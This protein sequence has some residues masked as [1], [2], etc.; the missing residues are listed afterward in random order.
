VFSRKTP[1]ASFVIGTDG[2]GHRVSVISLDGYF[3]NTP[4]AERPAFI[5][6]NI[7]SAEKGARRGATQTIKHRK[8]KQAI[9]AYHKPE[10]I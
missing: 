2:G 1:T 9:Y 8:P 7:E 4:E 6:I 10:D 5:K 3:G